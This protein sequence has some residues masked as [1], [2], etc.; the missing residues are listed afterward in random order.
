MFDLFLVY[1][2]KVTDG[3][4]V[5]EL[6]TLPG[7]GISFALH[8]AVEKF[9][10]ALG[11]TSAMRTADKSDWIDRMLRGV[12]GAP[13][14]AFRQSIILKTARVRTELR[15]APRAAKDSYPHMSVVDAVVIV[16]IFV[17]EAMQ[18]YAYISSGILV[19]SAESVVN[20]TLFESYNLSQVVSPSSS[21]EAKSWFLDSADSNLIWLHRCVAEI[22]YLRICFVL[23]EGAVSN[24]PKDSAGVLEKL[25]SSFAS[26]NSMLAPC[27]I[28]G[29][30][31]KLNT[32]PWTVINLEIAQFRDFP[33]S[34]L[35][36]VSSDPARDPVLWID[37]STA[38]ADDPLEVEA[39]VALLS[40]GIKENI[41]FDASPAWKPDFN[42]S[43]LDIGGS[44]CLDVIN[45]L[46]LRP[47][48][49]QVVSFR[50][51]P[52]VAILC[53]GSISWT[54]SA[55]FNSSSQTVTA[56][57]LASSITA[58]WTSINALKALQLPVIENIATLESKLIISMSSSGCIGVVNFFCPGV[59]D[60]VF[61]AGVALDG[62][63]CASGR[64]LAATQ[65][66]VHAVC[67]PSGKML[68][69]LGLSEYVLRMVSGFC[70]EVFSS[71][72]A[73]TSRCFP[74]APVVYSAAVP[75]SHA[76]ALHAQRCAV[77]VYA[78]ICLAMSIA[79]VINT[80]RTK[81]S[82]APEQQSRDGSIR[83]T[84]INLRFRQV[85][86]PV[87]WSVVIVATTTRRPPAPAQQSQTAEARPRQQDGSKESSATPLPSVHI[88]S[89]LAEVTLSIKGGAFMYSAKLM[90]LHGASAPDAVA[91]HVSS[92][93][94][95]EDLVRFIGA[96]H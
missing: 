81:L 53:K 6:K 21:S 57:R 27:L 37:G 42:V 28:S 30:V 65:D 67:M 12:E 41:P 76:L 17:D 36:A 80:V 13:S 58:R 79:K 85:M 66:P 20:V 16:T 1:S 88:R 45:D 92:P 87:R 8:A 38:A 40:Q 93:R 51:R 95:G 86:S 49:V 77:D 82:M 71:C 69:P 11:N 3:T 15:K 94:L 5:S 52:A 44:N 18:T 24:I 70:I 55:V 43:S 56:A 89:A 4:G 83:I 78:S 19:I 47:A 68:N 75:P 64:A 62:F 35:L 96:M 74:D 90:A 72:I 54:S 26:I 25:K 29:G 59:N 48:S 60:P 63:D 34:V 23:S 50:E 22:M 91:G 10:R 14:G 9:S 7:I 39:I 61:S 33:G 2:L 84:D 73:S 46:E 32:N 31:D